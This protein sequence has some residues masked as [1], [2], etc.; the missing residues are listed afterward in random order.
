MTAELISDEVFSVFL[1][2]CRL[3]SAIMLLPGF[4]ENY[5]LMRM[6]LIFALL[7]SVLLA[8]IL[9]GHIPPQPAITS[10][11]VA[12]VSYEIVF[13]L[14]I[15]AIARLAIFVLHFGGTMIAMQSG[16][17]AAAFFDPSENSQSTIT[18]N[19]LTTTVLA[20]V[21][22][23]GAYAFLLD[24]IIQTYEVYAPNENL[25]IDDM[26]L[27]FT[28]LGSD[29]LLAALNVAAPLT[30]VGLLI[31]VVM[32]LLN[33]LMPNFQVFF[34]IIPVQLLISLFVFMFS[35][36]GALYIALNFLDFSISTI[37]Q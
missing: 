12:L 30:I 35:L 11:F 16:L 1:V 9:D 24:G 13:G 25:P 28:R 32:G 3:G 8:P 37:L 26:A 15:G 23:T 14:F 6:R 29:A 21:F 36:S 34:V 18:S 5:V 19:I 27:A 4:G 33:R 22:V 31:Y 10:N 7:L 20:L 17:A 2:F